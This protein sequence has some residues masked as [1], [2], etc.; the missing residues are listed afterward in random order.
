MD[1]IKKFMESQADSKVA[2][3]EG[4][5]P[6]DNRSFNEVY[7]DKGIDAEDAVKES[8]VGAF[9]GSLMTEKKEKEE[10]KEEAKKECTCDI[11]SLSKDEIKELISKLLKKL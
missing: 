8:K 1:M 10:P 6:Q 3:R 2:L 7:G 4:F 5:V 9:L 11:D